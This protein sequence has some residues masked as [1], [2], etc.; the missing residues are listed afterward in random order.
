L[1]YHAPTNP[2]YSTPVRWLP[3]D[4]LT[5]DASATV[6]KLNAAG[7]YTVYPQV[8]DYEYRSLTAEPFY[9]D[10]K[11]Y[12]LTAAWQLPFAVLISSSSYITRELT[13]Y[14]SFEFLNEAAVTP[15]DHSPSN[16]ID[17]NDIHSFTQEIRFVSPAGQ[18]LHWTA[19][20]YFNHFTRYFPQDLPTPGLD[21]AIATLYDV[22]GFKS[23]TLYGTP[24]TNDL[25]YGVINVHEPEYALL[26]VG[27]YPL[28]S[29]LDLTLGLRYFNFKE[30]FNLYF[31]GFAGAIAPLSR[32]SAR[33]P[34]NRRA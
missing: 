4:G 5:I 32:S 19:G 30:D 10:F 22:P 28:S 14:S 6:E 2:S 8:G 24:E 20:G 16:N 3:T 12:N 1:G 34:S 33:E 7:R 26:G 13:L 18:K 9:D 27:T 23:Q 25:F 15:G 11:L 29:K 31:T 21:N 17:F